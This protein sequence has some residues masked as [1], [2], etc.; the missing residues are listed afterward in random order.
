MITYDI[1][2]VFVLSLVSYLHRYIIDLLTTQLMDVREH[3]QVSYEGEGVHHASPFNYTSDKAVQFCYDNGRIQKVWMNDEDSTQLSNLKRAILSHL[4]LSIDSLELPTYTIENDISGRCL[5]EFHPV[6]EETTSVTIMKT[7]YTT[8]CTDKYVFQSP[9][10][11]YEIDAPTQSSKLPHVTGIMQCEI[12]LKPTQEILQTSCNET[13][14]I[15]SSSLMQ[16]SQSVVVRTIT[17]I[18]LVRKTQS[19]ERKLH[20]TEILRFQKDCCRLTK[21]Y[22]IKKFGHVPREFLITVSSW[23]VKILQNVYKNPKVIRYSFS[24]FCPVHNTLR[25]T[26]KAEHHR[27]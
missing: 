1:N 11:N 15:T 23:I 27:G 24:M 3:S 9:L 14:N 6:K 8:G 22:H 21:F 20:K 10:T 25:Y 16:N 2:R 26:H 12:Q 13:L 5:T 4:Q 19:E 17:E 7:K 18:R